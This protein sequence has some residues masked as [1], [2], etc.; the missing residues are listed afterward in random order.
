MI[1][2]KSNFKYRVNFV[3]H[4]RF[5]DKSI[6]SFS[7]GTKIKHGEGYQ[8]FSVTVWDYLDISDGDSVLIDSI[9]SIEPNFYNGKVYMNISVTC[10]V[11]EQQK[12]AFAEDAPPPVQQYKK[13][14]TAPSQNQGFIDD[15]DIKPPF[16]V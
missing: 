4:R 10:R 13:P 3:K 9:D 12:Q 16:D 5:E 11:A 15:P 8:N 7:I 6:T 14:D 2:A 1:K